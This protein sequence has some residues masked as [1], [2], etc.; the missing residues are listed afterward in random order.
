M[1]VGH[2]LAYLFTQ[3]NLT[4]H[5][6]STAVLECPNFNWA[7][8]W[9]SL[10]QLV[11]CLCANRKYFKSGPSIGLCTVHLTIS[12][13]PTSSIMTVVIES[14]WLTLPSS[15]FSIN[16]SMSSFTMVITTI[17]WSSSSSLLSAL[18]SS[19]NSLC[20]PLLHF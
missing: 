18:F 3:Q 1:L 4:Q 19:S 13:P 7:W 9:H 12:R 8:Q 2:N 6:K 5:N 17:I 11:L 14:S 20:D 15:S 16:I 10:A